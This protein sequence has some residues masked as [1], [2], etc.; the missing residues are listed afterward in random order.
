MTTPTP[1]TGLVAI[2]RGVTPSEV[3]QIGTALLEE[4]ISA[5]E[6]PMN[7]PDPLRSI[8]LL[9]DAVGAHCAVGAGTV[10]TMDDLIRTESAGARIIV[11]PNTDAEIIAEA[12]SRGLLPYPGVATPTEAFTALKA[13]ARN[14]KLFPSDVLGIGGM[15]AIAAVL[16]AGTEMLPVG[17]VDETNLA[18][19]LTAGA[20]GAGIGSCLYRPG[21][22]AN[23][24]RARARTLA[25][26]WSSRHTPA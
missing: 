2:L 21:D 15:K 11:A 8:E 14:L 9:A 25:Q 10:T 19:W 22:T 4:G 13:G 24:V 26:I 20:G 23:A 6:V 5:I 1:A 3:V 12:V 16:P 18:A 7:S 17:G